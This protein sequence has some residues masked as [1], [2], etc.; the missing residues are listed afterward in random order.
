MTL[1]IVSCLAAGRLAFPQTTFRGMLGTQWRVAGR[2]LRS[3][4]WWRLSA[5]M[6]GKGGGW[7]V[8]RGGACACLCGNLLC[9]RLSGGHLAGAHE[10]RQH[11]RARLEHKSRQQSLCH[12]PKET[13]DMHQA[14]LSPLR[15]AFVRCLC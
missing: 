1:I 7:L 3:S 15:S 6:A 4:S 10:T 11:Y 12:M 2:T 5:C 9:L 8:W 14:W 13:V